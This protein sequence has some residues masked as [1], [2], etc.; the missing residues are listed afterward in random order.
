M[1]IQDVINEMK[2]HDFS[3]IRVCKIVE[4]VSLEYLKGISSM[5]M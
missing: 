4:F 3:F 2:L 5:Q 1:H